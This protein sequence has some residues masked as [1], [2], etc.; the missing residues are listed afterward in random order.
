MKELISPTAKELTEKLKE[1]YGISQPQVYKRFRSLKLQSSKQDG[2]VWI[3][4]DQLNELDQLDQHLAQGGKL[5]DYSR[6]G[7]VKAEA[8][9]IESYSLPV[10]TQPARPFASSEEARENL[11]QSAQVKATGKMI[12][13]NLLVQ[14]YLENPDLLPPELREAV[15]KSE[16]LATP[17]PVDPWQYAQEAF[18][19]MSASG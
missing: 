7:I 1:R 16:A 13:E 5:E 2:E 8:S 17:K 18:R 15:A 12:L 19:L 10:E 9:E 11:E 6:N 4:S 3:T 14:K